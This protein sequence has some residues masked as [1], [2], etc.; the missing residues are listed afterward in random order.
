MQIEKAAIRQNG[1]IYT[2]KRHSE[3]IKDMVNNYGLPKPIT[4]EQGFINELGEF[5][6]RLA[7]A[8]ITL[9]SGQIKELQNPP[10]LY[11]EDLY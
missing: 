9:E 8:K 2:G 11:S 1:N 3:I 10:Y 7:A 5:F 6:N 4:G